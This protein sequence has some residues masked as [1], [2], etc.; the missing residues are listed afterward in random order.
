MPANSE[1]KSPYIPHP[2]FMIAHAINWSVAIRDLKRF[3]LKSIP[4]VIF[5]IFHYPN[6]FLSI[7]PKPCRVQHNL[8]AVSA[9]K[10]APCVRICF[11]NKRYIFHVRC[12]TS[13]LWIIFSFLGSIVLLQPKVVTIKSKVI[14][15]NCTSKVVAVS[16]VRYQNA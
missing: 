6:A 12:F 7:I 1:E 4:R 11:H 16:G 15:F 14:A 3:Q 10:S 8:K 13:A 2:S 9:P 5:I